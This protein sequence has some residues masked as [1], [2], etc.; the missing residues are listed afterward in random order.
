MTKVQAL[1]FSFMLFS[2]IRLDCAMLFMVWTC[3]G[4]SPTGGKCDHIFIDHTICRGDLNS[5]KS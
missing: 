2:P 3:S 1:N 4:S 5:H